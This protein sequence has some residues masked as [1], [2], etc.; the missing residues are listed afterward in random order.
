[1]SAKYSCLQAVT[2]E[3]IA[4][5]PGDNLNF[6]RTVC[7]QLIH[8]AL[9]T[10][11]P[12]IASRDRLPIIQIANKFEAEFLQY[13]LIHTM[14]RA[15]KMLGIEQWAAM[16]VALDVID[17]LRAARVGVGQ[18][19]LLLDPIH[20][21]NARKKAFSAL[22][23]K[24]QGNETNGS[25][26]PTT[27]TLAIAEGLVPMPDTSWEGRFALAVKF[28]QPGSSL[29]VEV[30][31]SSECYLWR[32]PPAS[33]EATAWAVYDRY[34]SASRTHSAEMGMGFSIIQAPWRR[35]DWRIKTDSYNQYTL[36]SP[37]WSCYRTVSTVERLMSWELGNLHRST[38][39]DGRYGA[40]KFS[41][42]LPGGLASLPRIRG[43][44]E[45]QTLYVDK[46]A[47]GT[48]MPSDCRCG[49]RVTTRSAID[50]TAPTN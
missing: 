15:M 22:Q 33:D 2:S 36:Y 24:L 6:R 12:E 7:S 17:A 41:E 37:M 32:F 8:A 43:C 45:C 10:V 1:M 13:D 16:R 42:L 47:E 5:I 49:K 46:P 4:K 11:S 20:K 19:Q 38:L 9:G 39:R 35:T 50:Q 40:A 26:P 27:A 28:P 21:K 25:L 14:Q 18:V 3:L 44:Y 48:G 31:N 23:K 34:F 29:L 30:V